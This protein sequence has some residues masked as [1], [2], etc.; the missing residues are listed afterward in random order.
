MPIT[1]LPIEATPR[2]KQDLLYST[3]LALGG[4]GSGITRLP[5][6][7]VPRSEQD[8][9]YSIML[10]AQGLSTG[11][12]LE[13][14]SQA[15]AEEGLD[16]ETAMTPL[17]VA[18]KIAFD[19]GAPTTIGKALLNLADPSA[20]TFLRMNADNTASALSATDMRTALGLDSVTPII[21]SA[22]NVT[23]LTSGAPAD[24]ASITVPSW[25]TRWMLV[26]SSVGATSRLIAESAAGSLSAATFVVL[27][28]AGGSGNF[29]RLS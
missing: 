2:S 13:L 12:G 17:R 9:L 10:A 22:K 28:A 14:S 5:H 20:I 16:N 21:L 26:G 8:L 29:A 6:T 3:L 18:Q 24:I 19:F 11:G 15:Q 7:E 27:D 4:G 25:V 1:K 23:V